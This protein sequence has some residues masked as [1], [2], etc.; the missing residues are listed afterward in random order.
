MTKIRVFFVATATI[1][2]PLLRTLMADDRFEVDLVVTAPDRPAGRKMAL[3]ASPV[4]AAAE[5]LT[6]PVFQPK[7]INSTESVERLRALAA[8]LMVVFAYGQ[9]LS[10]EVL[11]L[12]PHGCVNVHASLLPKYRGAS[13]IQ[14]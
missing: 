10:A 11:A 2:I 13:P 1:A 3:K 7:D 6:L 8:D 12:P 14:S 4:K 9:I 5:E